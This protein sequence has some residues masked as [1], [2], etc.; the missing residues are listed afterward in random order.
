MKNIIR[1]EELAML[2]LCVIALSHHHAAWWWYLLLVLGPD[3]SMV[4]YLAGNKIGAI[5]VQLV[6]S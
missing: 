4:G 6:S 1:L 2:G 5:S 3:I